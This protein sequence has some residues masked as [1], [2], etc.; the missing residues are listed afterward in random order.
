MKKQIIKP[1]I[2]P[3]FMELLPREQ[4][5]FNQ[6][7]MIIQNTFEKNGFLPMDTPIIEKSEV[8]LAKGGEETDKQTY[9]FD[10]GRNNLALRFDLTV[11]F[12]RYSAQY[13]P[14]LTFPFRRY[15]IG[16]VFRGERNQ[17]GRFREFY[18]CD[19]DVISNRELSIANDAE[20]PSIMHTIFKRI[21]LKNFKI[22]INNRKLLNGFLE[23]LEI[24]DSTKVLRSIDKIYK[25]GID[26]FK[27]EMN[28][29]GVTEDKIFSIIDFISISGKNDEILDSL[30]K[31]GMENDTFLSGLREL[32]QTITYMKY[33]G[34]PDESYVID[35]KIAR[36]LDYYTGTVYETI[37]ND[38]P[39]FGSICSGGR[40]D[41][42]AQ[43]YTIQKLQGVG[44]S[45]GLTRLFSLMLEKGMLKESQ[46]GN[47]TRV[48][49]LT[50]DDNVEFAAGIA[51]KMKSHGINTQIYFEDDKLARKLSYANKLGIEYVIIIGEREI[52]NGTLQVKN[53]ITGEQKELNIKDTISAL[54][55]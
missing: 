9:S 39:E 53:M 8:L 52:K 34:I 32:E 6:I 14:E 43:Y 11:P 17:K 41:N 22:R 10:R 29:L 27:V 47:L 12:A 54:G 2:L 28:G 42:L 1:T 37:L 49:I 13:L 38:Y 55:G 36:G 48:L 40:Y 25:I 19:I 23:Y 31:L 20:L 33:F 45:I 15:Q 44:M 50:M 26:T 46:F 3:G 51:E 5:Q 35:L 16:K 7:I 18:Q 30:K 21:G 4:M 24:F